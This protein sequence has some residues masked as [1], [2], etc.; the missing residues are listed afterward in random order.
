MHIMTSLYDWHL[1]DIRYLHGSLNGRHLML[2]SETS[3]ASS[4]YDMHVHV[5]AYHTVLPVH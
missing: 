1:V 4:L 3:T 5:D 2:W